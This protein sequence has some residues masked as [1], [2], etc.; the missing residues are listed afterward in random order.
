MIPSLLSCVVIYSLFI[1]AFIVY[2]GF[3][4][5]FLV[6]LCFAVF[7]VLSGFAIILWGKRELVALLRLSS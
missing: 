4:V 7:G 5:C 1:V 6:L 3:C 2:R